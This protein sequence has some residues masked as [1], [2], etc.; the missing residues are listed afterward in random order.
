MTF[1]VPARERPKPRTAPDLDRLAAEV[2]VRTPAIKAALSKRGIETAGDLLETPPRAW[3]DYSEGVTALGPRAARA[4][5][6]APPAHR[7]DRRPATRRRAHRTPLAFA[8]RCDRRAALAAHARGRQDR[9]RPAGLRGAPAAPG[10]AG[11]APRR[12]AARR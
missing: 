3:R 6:A 7:G 5:G 9:E 12:R 8:P 2:G 4:R 10:R 11:R 1:A